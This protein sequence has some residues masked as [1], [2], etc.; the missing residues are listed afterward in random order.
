MEHIFTFWTW[1]DDNVRMILPPSANGAASV[2]YTYTV[3]GLNTGRGMAFDG[4]HIHLADATDDNVRMILPPSADGASLCRLHLYCQRFRQSSG[5]D[6]RWDTHPHFRYC[7]L[8][9][10]VRMILPPSA[11][12]AASVVYTYTVSGLNSRQGYG[13][14]WDT[15]PSCG[16]P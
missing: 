12:G 6:F 13:F 5:H 7:R 11:D 1:H 2:V 16:L 10:N 15:Y 9:T 14:R 4:T 8:V 3:S